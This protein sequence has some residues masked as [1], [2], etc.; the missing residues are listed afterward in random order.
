MANYLRGMQLFDHGLS[1]L[2]VELATF[3]ATTTSSTVKLNWNTAT[4]VNNYG[5]EVEKKI[6]KQVQIDNTVWEKIGFVNGNGNSNS[7]KDYSF[8]D[9]K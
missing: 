4:E 8:V 3:S 2:P 5:F 9:D 6:L 1:A 7:P